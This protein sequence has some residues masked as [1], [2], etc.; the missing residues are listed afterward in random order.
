MSSDHEPPFR[1]LVTSAT[2]SQSLNVASIMDAIRDGS[3]SI[4]EYQRDSSQW[5]TVKKSLFIESII[6]NLTV[7][8]LIVYP[9]DNPETGLETRQVIDGQQRLTTIR[10]YLDGRFSLSGEQE[11][12]YAENVGPIIQG[13]KFSE[14]PA[15]IQRQVNTYTLNL[16]GSRSPGFEL[17]AGS[18]QGRKQH[19]R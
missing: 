4:P 3:Y 16:I 8:P 1:P 5:D 2:T 13:R 12:E 10:E 7:P 17:E 18:R 14:L 11:V 9:E 6:N 19:K 15:R